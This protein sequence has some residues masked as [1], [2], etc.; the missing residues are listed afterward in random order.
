MADRTAGKADATGKPPQKGQ[1]K[2]VAEGRERIRASREKERQE[3]E[4]GK[5]RSRGR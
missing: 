2:R 1:E 5:D 3:R 4:Q